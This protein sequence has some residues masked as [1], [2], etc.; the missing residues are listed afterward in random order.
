MVLKVVWYFHRYSILWKKLQLNWL[1]IS[2]SVSLENP[3]RDN[4]KAKNEGDMIFT[5]VDLF[6]FNDKWLRPSQ[7]L[8][9]VSNILVS[10]IHSDN[11]CLSLCNTKSHYMLRQYSKCRVTIR[12]ALYL[13]CDKRIYSHCHNARHPF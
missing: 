11:V 6:Y 12:Y 3:C 1:I 2:I 9:F 4:I 8:L 7:Y 10:V 5:N 13:Y